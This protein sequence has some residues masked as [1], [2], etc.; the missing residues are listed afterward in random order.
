MGPRLLWMVLTCL[1]TCAPAI[2]GDLDRD[3]EFI[4]QYARRNMTLEIDRMDPTRG[5]AGTVRNDGLKTI[6]H[7]RATA[8]FL[9]RQGR[10]TGEYEFSVLG[11]EGLSGSGDLRPR[12]LGPGQSRDF[13]AYPSS[14][15]EGWSD[16]YEAEITSIEFESARHSE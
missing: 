16:R 8:R 15:P 5:A 6:R 7:A 12:V 11:L 4:R 9:D 10:R 3:K 1:M 13:L 2:S 14:V